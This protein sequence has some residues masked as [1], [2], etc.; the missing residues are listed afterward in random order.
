M[1][2]SYWGRRKKIAQVSII[3]FRE[4]IGEGKERKGKEKEGKGEGGPN[5]CPRKTE[6][7]SVY[8]DSKA[9]P[10]LILL[11][12]DIS[13]IAPHSIPNCVCIELVLGTLPCQCQGDVVGN[14]TMGYR[15]PFI[16]R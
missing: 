11:P 15:K 16:T 9:G 8:L 12:N 10:V 7:S 2:C 3:F 1:Y 4:E 5:A 14:G 6:S 13:M